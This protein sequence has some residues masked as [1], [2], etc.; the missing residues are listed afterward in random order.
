[1]SGHLRCF[2]CCFGSIQD[3]LPQFGHRFQRSHVSKYEADSGVLSI[4]TIE[5][6]L[7]ILQS[8]ARLVNPSI[9]PCG[10]KEDGIRAMAKTA[11]HSHDDNEAAIL[12]LAGQ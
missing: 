5:T 3:R 6:R 9:Q 7:L 12:H 2:I 11:Q 1:M 10:L 8:L 4:T